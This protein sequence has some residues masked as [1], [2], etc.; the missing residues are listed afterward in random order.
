MFEELRE[1]FPLKQPTEDGASARSAEEEIFRLVAEEIHRGLRRQGLWAKAIAE[2][3]GSE[4]LARSIYVRLRAQ[5]IIDERFLREK[6]EAV[7]HAREREK[8]DAAKRN[9]P[10]PFEKRSAANHA[11]KGRSIEKP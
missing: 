7:D 3:D 1:R 4:E 5:S 2:A 6:Q 10:T 8:R 9:A 11:A